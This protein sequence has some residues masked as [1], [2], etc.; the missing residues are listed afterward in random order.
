[1]GQKVNPQILRLGTIYNWSSRWFDDKKYKDVL[2]E[3]FNLRKA[4][5]VKLGAAGVSEIEIERSIN[6]LRLIINGYGNWKG[7]KRLGRDQRLL[8]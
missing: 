5:M 8:I 6:S 7:R 3:D 4:L 1:M 2:L